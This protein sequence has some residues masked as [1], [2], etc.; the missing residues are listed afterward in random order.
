MNK[1]KWHQYHPKA[2]YDRLNPYDTPLTMPPPPHPD[3]DDDSSSVSTIQPAYTGRMSRAVSASTISSVQS[4]STP[5]S[6]VQGASQKRYLRQQ[7]TDIINSEHALH[8]QKMRNAHTERLQRR[9]REYEMLL[10]EEKQEQEMKD[11]QANINRL[12]ALWG[13]KP[14]SSMVLE[15]EDENEDDILANKQLLEFF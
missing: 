8:M 15:E 1:A 13:E 5:Q 12:R 2:R 4:E 14:R 11:I 10:E 3:D 7:S 6:Q 9:R